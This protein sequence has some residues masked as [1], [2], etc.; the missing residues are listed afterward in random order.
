MGGAV[1]ELRAEIHTHVLIIKHYPTFLEPYLAAVQFFLRT[2]ER[3]EGTN[4]DRAIDDIPIDVVITDK[5]IFEE[6][7]TEI[8]LLVENREVTKVLLQGIETYRQLV[9]SPATD[10]LRRWY[11]LPWRKDKPM[12]K[13]VEKLL[14]ELGGPEVLNRAVVENPLDDYVK[15]DVKAIFSAVYGGDN[16]VKRIV[17]GNI[18]VVVE[19]MTENRESAIVQLSGVQRICQLLVD[20][21]PESS[22]AESS[23]VAGAATAQD[24]ATLRAERLKLF[25][26]LETFGAVQM[27]TEVLN[28]F[29]EN[30]YL[31]LYVHVCRFISFVAIE[32]K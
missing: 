24:P 12:P 11:D 4:S 17:I 18:P 21:G 7:S 1:S 5:R 9:L 14:E 16:A 8:E 3:G 30:K 2:A 26:D 10:P 32:G 27:L 15:N 25:D 28:R 19:M 6:A 22:G 23:G 31:S 13:F 29:D 20:V